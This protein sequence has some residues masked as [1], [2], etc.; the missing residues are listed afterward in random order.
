M[1]PKFQENLDPF[2]ENIHSSPHFFHSVSIAPQPPRV[3][4]GFGVYFPLLFLAKNKNF[5][6]CSIAA[7]SCCWF[8]N[9]KREKEHSLG[10]KTLNSCF[11]HQANLAQEPSFMAFPGSISP[12][13]TQVALF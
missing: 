4:S 13:L 1:T 3:R 9:S 7:E 5:L 10:V 2:L 6:Y 12:G 11:C 8:H